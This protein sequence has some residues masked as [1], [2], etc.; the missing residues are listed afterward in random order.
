MMSFIEYEGYD[1]WSYV[2]NFS[3]N[4]LRKVLIN[5]KVFRKGRGS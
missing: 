1:I 4:I 5:W 2:F 3:K